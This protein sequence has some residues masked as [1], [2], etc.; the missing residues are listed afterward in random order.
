MKFDKR[1]VSVR[2]DL[3]SKAD[4]KG[5]PKIEVEFEYPV[6]EDFMEF[7]PQIEEAIMDLPVE[8]QG[9]AQT[10]DYFS[11]KYAMLKLKSLQNQPKAPAAPPENADK[12]PEPNVVPIES[13]NSRGSNVDDS[14]AAYTKA[15]TAAK[16]SG[17]WEQVFKMKGIAGFKR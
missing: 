6:Y 9:A 4:S 12:R 7:V 8:Q 5:N 16:D 17:D 1:K 13:A 2:H 3:G 14:D 10:M 11:N 15:V